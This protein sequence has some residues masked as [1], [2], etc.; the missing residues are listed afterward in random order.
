METAPQ[1][2]KI[3][4]LNPKGGSGKSTIATNMAA[5]YAWKG[6]NTALMDMDP[7]GSGMRWL[8]LRSRN[9]PAIT[10]INGFERPACAARRTA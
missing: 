4:L 3:V 10:A 9:L 6:F 1:L 2:Q 8:R 7:Q 5:Y